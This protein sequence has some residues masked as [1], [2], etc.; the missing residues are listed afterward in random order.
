MVF[1][2][3]IG[4]LRAVAFKAVFFRLFFGHIKVG[5]MMLVSGHVG[6]GNGRRQPEQAQNRAAQQEKEQVP[7]PGLALFWGLGCHGSVGA[8]FG[9]TVGKSIR[10]WQSWEGFRFHFL[11]F[12]RA[13]ALKYFYRA[14]H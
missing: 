9:V 14:S 1:G 7:E 6:R 3:G 12:Y 2:Q 11:D 10:R 5:R 8:G 4:H 13:I